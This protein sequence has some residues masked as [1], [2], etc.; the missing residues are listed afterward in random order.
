MLASTRLR[1]SKPTRSHDGRRAIF[2]ER[3][4]AAATL[5]SPAPESAAVWH[6]ETSTTHIAEN[7]TMQVF[8]E[9]PLSGLFERGSRSLQCDFF[10][11]PVPPSLYVPEHAFPPIWLL[12]S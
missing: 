1:Y 9:A 4:L 7:T 12:R 11:A 6:G 10:Y 3:S 8:I 2:W 5:P